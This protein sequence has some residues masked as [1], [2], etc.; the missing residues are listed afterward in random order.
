MSTSSKAR[1]RTNAPEGLYSP[2]KSRPSFRNTKSSRAIRITSDRLGI[3]WPGS[4]IF[5]RSSSI[6]SASSGATRTLICWRLSIGI[7]ESVAVATC[8]C[9]H[10]KSAYSCIMYTCLLQAERQRNDQSDTSSESPH[11]G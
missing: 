1:D 8:L 11:M 4:F 5:I 2:E 3:E 9:L 7:R 10:N 6:E